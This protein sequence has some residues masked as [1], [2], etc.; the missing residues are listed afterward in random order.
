MSSSEKG[1]SDKGHADQR[2]DPVYDFLY[3]D[4]RR[5]YSFLERFPLGLN[6]D[7]QGA[8]KG[9]VLAGDSVSGMCHD[10][11]LLGGFAGAC[12]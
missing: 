7:S 9:G 12:G 8:R 4:A 3:H 6:R 2:R 1:A 5:I 11:A 10:Q